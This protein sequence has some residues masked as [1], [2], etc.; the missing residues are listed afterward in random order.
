MASALLVA[1]LGLGSRDARADQLPNLHRTIELARAR[2]IVVA[3]ARA[4]LGVAQ[5]QVIGARVSSIG[6]PYSDIQIDHGFGG[7]GANTLQALS[8]NYL[9]VDIAG[10]RGKRIEEAERL[11]EWRKLGVQDARALATGE[12]IIAY[13]EVVVGIARVS[14]ARGGEQIARDEAKYFAGRFE[15]KDTTLYEKSLAEGEVTRWVQASA[16]A[17]VRVTGARARLAQVTGIAMLAL[18]AQMS[19]KDVSPPVLRRQW[20]EPEVANVVNRSPLVARL[21]AERRYW[22]SSVVR[23][24]R[25]RIPPFTFEV[26]AGRGTAGE[27]RLGGGAV[28]TFPITRRFQGEIARAEAASDQATRRLDLYRNIIEVRLRSAVESLETIT[29]ALEEIDTNGL[30]AFE[31]AVTAAEEGYKAGKVDLTRTLLARRDLA[32]AR[33]RRLDMIEAAWRAYAELAV[34]SGELP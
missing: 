2:A 21:I 10:Q 25:E 18:P 5:A 28:V 26:I 29:K 4:E 6:N 31:R 33:A 17:Q 13:G 27:L 32:F 11:V 15:A 9:P 20:R 8:Y 19:G 30:P 24:E 23:Y 14:E 34:L 12:A 3:E 1:A 16:E 22:D 7:T